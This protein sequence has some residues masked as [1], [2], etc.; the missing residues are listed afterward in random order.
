MLLQRSYI[1]PADLSGHDNAVFR[2]KQELTVVFL[3]R[4]LRLNIDRFKKT[5][6]VKEVIQP[7]LENIGLESCD[8]LQQLEAL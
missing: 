5:S 7:I 8:N 3:G 2:L 1:N 6:V 4:L